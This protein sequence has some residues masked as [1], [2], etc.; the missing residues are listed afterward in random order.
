[1]KRTESRPRLLVLTQHYRPEPNFITAD[2]AESLCENFDVTVVTAHPSYPEGRFYPGSRWWLPLRKRERGATVWRLPMYP[3]RG[4]SKPL[5]FLSYLSFAGAAAIWA[6]LVALRPRVV[7]VYH[8]PF[9]VGLAAMWYRLLGC[10]IVFTCADLWPESFLAAQVAGHGL[11]MRLMFAYSR[12]INRIATLLICSTRGTMRRYAAD[13]IP[14]SALCYV[15][16]WVEGVPLNRRRVIV[17]D[18]AVPRIVYA[19]NLGPAQQLETLVRAAG[20]LHG[21]GVSVHFDVYGTGSSEVELRE[22]AV[23]AGAANVTFHGRIEPARA[24]ERASSAHGQVVC[25]RK[26]ALFSMTIPS[27]ISFSFAAGSPVLYGLTGE[28]AELVAESGGGIAFDPNDPATLVAAVKLL[29]D[30][31]P[32]MRREMGD[33]LRRYYDEHF[34]RSGLLA[35]YKRVFRQ[36]GSGRAPRLALGAEGAKVSLAG[37]TESHNDGPK[38]S[39]EGAM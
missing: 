31:S 35:Q 16:V 28:S 17:T 14:P 21:E 12:A 6:P 9:T 27:K 1:M 34:E 10:R 20:R 33:A 8:G 19:G 13:G 2:V 36:C 3:Y 38:S 7:W 15:P 22:L 18:D 37:G 5:R 26:T 25:L 32:E 39:A 29:L 4:R 24:F 11:I 23:Q 30:L